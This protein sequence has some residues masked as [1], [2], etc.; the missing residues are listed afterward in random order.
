MSEPPGARWV[1]NRGIYSSEPQSTRGGL[2]SQ[3]DNCS[4]GET[5]VGVYKLKEA[6]EKFYSDLQALHQRKCDCSLAGMA[7][8]R[9]SSR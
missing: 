8:W 5:S 4:S 6:M 3:M 9:F 2:K 1:V 7:T